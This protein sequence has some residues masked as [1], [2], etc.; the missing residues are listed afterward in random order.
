MVEDVYDGVVVAES[1]ALTVQR[2][3]PY[4]SVDGL[5]DDELA[6]PAELARQAEMEQWG[7]VLLLP[8]KDGKSLLSPAA[9]NIETWRGSVTGTGR[10]RWDRN[11][12]GARKA[13][14]SERLRDT[15]I[16]LDIVKER[17]P[18]RAKYLV[19][20]HLR[21]GLIELD[22][23]ADADM[24]A[25]AR[26]YQKARRLREDIRKIEE[27]RGGRL[28]VRARRDAKPRANR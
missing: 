2:P 3:A 7:P 22:H 14:L 19:L 24:L 27:T 25:L 28:Q 9:G 21:M 13:R 16:L 5:D 20:K 15:L 10:E 1:A 8:E 12:V 11:S 17:L 4:G 26:L 23:I 6:D 18:G